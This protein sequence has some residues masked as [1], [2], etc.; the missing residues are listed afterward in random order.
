MSWRLRTGLR[1][2]FGKLLESITHYK[3]LI[4]KVAT[5]LYQLLSS[6]S[7]VSH[8][9]SSVKGSSKQ[10]VLRT[11]T[12]STGVETDTRDFVV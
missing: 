6:R 11:R 4:T 12:W 8:Q 9:L 10:Q 1:T 7:N 2:V 5:L 3:F